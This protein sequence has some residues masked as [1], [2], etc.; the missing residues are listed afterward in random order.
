[1]HLTQGRLLLVPPLFILEVQQMAVGS[2]V[3]RLIIPPFGDP[4]TL[5]NPFHSPPLS[6]QSI[7]SFHYIFAISKCVPMFT[8]YFCQNIKSSDPKSSLA[9]LRMKPSQGTTFFTRSRI[10]RERSPI[11]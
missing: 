2:N 8:T 11:H 5:S 6:N 9:S 10:W 4:A 3:A 7:W 1:M